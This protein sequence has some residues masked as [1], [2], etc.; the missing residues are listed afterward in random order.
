MY[1]DNT[2]TPKEAVR[3][4]ALGT[5]AKE[6]MRYGALAVAA[7]HFVGRILGPSLDLM[8]TSVELLKYEGLVEAV[9]GEGME[10]DALLRMTD[11][12]WD[13]LR[14][15]LTTPVRQGASELNKLIITLKFRFLHLLDADGRRDQ[16]DLLIDTSEGE[17]ARLLD[18]RQN[19]RGRP[20]PP[21]RMAG[22]RHRS[23]GTAAGLAGREP[24]S[25][26]PGGL[27]E[28]KGRSSISPAWC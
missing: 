2:L 9:D 20:R 14:T 21:D 6:P 27:N 11:K 25:T 26:E 22:P 1:T 24:I 3:L 16:V 19:P 4:C 18:L 15:L 5:L 17:I 8:G 7:R 10:D 12:G 23:S 13:T 28:E